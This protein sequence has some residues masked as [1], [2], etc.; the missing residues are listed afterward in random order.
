MSGVVSLYVTNIS[1]LISHF[2]FL[3]D[4]IS[5]LVD[6]LTSVISRI[7]SMPVRFILWLPDHRCSLIRRP[8]CGKKS[9]PSGENRAAWNTQNRQNRPFLTPPKSSKMAIFCS[10]LE[11]L[12]SSNPVGS[13]WE[14]K[15]RLYIG[16]P[17]KGGLQKKT[18]KSSKI[19]RFW[20]FSS[21]NSILRSTVAQF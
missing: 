9:P 19:D 15:N 2:Y 16:S 8:G 5:P 12:R 17:H 6:M 1:I 21:L 14:P 4:A 11:T 20:L 18:I 13:P 7:D 10:F 3:L